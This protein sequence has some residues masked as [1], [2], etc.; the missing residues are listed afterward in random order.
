MVEEKLP[1][2]AF[3]CAKCDYESNS[4][5]KFCPACGTKR[6]ALIL[7][8]NPFKQ[9]GLISLLSYFFLTVLILL[10][11][12]VSED[13]LVGFFED[14]VIFSALFAVID[15]V[16]AF[17]NGRESFLFST[18]N[19]KI[20]PLVLMTVGLVVFGFLVDFFADFLNRSIFEGS[21]FDGFVDVYPLITVIGFQC[22]HPAIFEELA[23]RGFVINN[24]RS[25]SN[26]KTAIIVSGFLFGLTHL[27]FVSLIWLVPIGMLFGY[28]RIRYNT[29]WYGVIGHFIY[30]LTVTLIERGIF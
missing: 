22:L 5:F 11:Y 25:L 27:A 16:F 26:D 29:L 1:S 28:L 3:S 20:K 23:Y 13:Y 21:P 14:M 17:I 6:I 18:K 30:N 24:I 8:K 10:L 19:V 9:R 7:E 15:I 4:D 12:S 2:E